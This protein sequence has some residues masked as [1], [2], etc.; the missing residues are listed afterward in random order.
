MGI[1]KKKKK[2]MEAN[3]PFRAQ[4]SRQMAGWWVTVP[5]FK[6]ISRE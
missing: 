4:S 5:T 2:A 1:E 3:I 6:L